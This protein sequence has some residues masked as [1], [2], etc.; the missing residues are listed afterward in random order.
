MLTRV[1]PASEI[2]AKKGLV[3]EASAHIYTE[4]ELFKNKR[5]EVLGRFIKARARYLRASGWVARAPAHPDAPTFWLDPV[6]KEHFR[7]DAAAD[8]QE[9]RDN[10]LIY[11]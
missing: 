6:D 3:L 5:M 1:V 4:E 10:G 2:M 8:I 9:Q 11:R 7:E